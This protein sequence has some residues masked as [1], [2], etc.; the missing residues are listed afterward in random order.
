MIFIFSRYHTA[1]NAVNTWPMTVATAAPIMP[2][3]KTKMKIG[4][5]MML[6]T[7]PA[8]VEIMANL[9]LPSARIM[10][11]MACPNI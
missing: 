4:S 3:L 1:R 5:R 7:A 8:N 10:G 11:F 2:H 6:I 9:G